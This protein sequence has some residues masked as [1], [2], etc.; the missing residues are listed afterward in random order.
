MEANSLSPRCLL[1]ADD[2]QR[3]P[4]PSVHLEGD[5][6]AG[7][8]GS[9]PDAGACG[10]FATGMRRTARRRV[11]ADYAAGQHTLKVD[12]ALRGDFATGQRAKRS[13]APQTDASAR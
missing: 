3:S 1:V 10:D 11:I 9:V 6:A 8:R 13:D 5:F 7:L 4:T 12:G 2:S